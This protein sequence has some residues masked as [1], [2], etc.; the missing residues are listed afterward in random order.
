MDTYSK[1]TL[2]TGT[3]LDDPEKYQR[4]IGKLIYL[5]IT[6]PDI[7]FTVHVLNKF[8]HSPTNSNYQ[9]GIRVLIYLDGSP[10]QGIL[11]ASRTTTQLTA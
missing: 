6:R 9:A 10:A 1:L 11:L 4:L 5:T 7:T 2:E 8:M 3:L